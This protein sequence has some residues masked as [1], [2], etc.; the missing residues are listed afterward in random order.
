MLR[1]ELYL[2][3]CLLETVCIVECSRQK[4]NLLGEQLVGFI[5]RRSAV[6][7]KEDCQLLAT[8]MH[9][10]ILFWGTAGDAEFVIW[11]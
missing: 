7:T 10:C 1:K 8:L 9:L 2:R 6:S 3:L 4:D 5:D 11:E